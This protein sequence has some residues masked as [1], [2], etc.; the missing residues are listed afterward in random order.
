MNNLSQISQ[1]PPPPPTPPRISQT[2]QSV[3]GAMRV[4][5]IIVILVL[6]T[7]PTAR[8]TNTTA[9]LPHCPTYCGWRDGTSGCVACPPGSRSRGGVCTPCPPFSL[10]SARS[11]LYGLLFLA[12]LP[13]AHLTAQMALLPSLPSLPAAS[14][15]AAETVLAAAGTYGLL[16]SQTKDDEGLPFCSPDALADF[17]TLLTSDALPPCAYDAVY[18]L[19]SGPLVYVFV[20]GVGIGLRVVATG[21]AVWLRLAS[22]KVWGEGESVWARM[23]VRA[24]LALPLL[25]LVHFVGAGLVYYAFPYLLY[26]GTVV[27]D[28]S[29]MWE[30]GGVFPLWRRSCVG[31]TIFRIFLNVGSTTAMA[32]F[33]LDYSPLY[34][35]VIVPGLVLPFVIY[36]VVVGC[37]TN[38]NSDTPTDSSAS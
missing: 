1:N 22:P 11:N 8:G 36:V 14:C 27:W 5:I 17:Y 24:A 2:S 33:F 26:V 6:G 7:T 13:T 34:L 3:V 38:T 19:W 30:V 10:A 18:P 31:S 23:I 29:V 15:I 28:V 9:P 20:A 32:S 4:S 21:L 37:C 35:A 25:G 12:L 16:A